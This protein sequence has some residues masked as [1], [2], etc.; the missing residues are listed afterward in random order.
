MS[1]VNRNFQDDVFVKIK[2]GLNAITQTFT[3][4]LANL[5][6]SDC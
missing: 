4:R 5:E 1:V 3:R 6:K 2:G